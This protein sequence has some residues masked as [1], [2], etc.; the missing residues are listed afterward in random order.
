MPAQPRRLSHSIAVHLAAI[1]GATV[2]LVVGIGFLAA[3]TELS[4]AVVSSGVVVVE[5]NVKKVQHPTGGVVKELLV[6]DGATVSAGDIL[7]RL[8]EAVAN[9]NL[10]AVSKTYAELQA[11][12][13]RLEAERDDA[14]DIQFPDELLQQDDRAI[15]SMIDGERRLLQ[16]RRNSA[17]NRKSQLQRRIAQLQDEIGGLTDQLAAKQKELELIQKELA[18]VES[19]WQQQLVAI[20]RFTAL[21]REAARLLGDSGRLKA[22][23]AQSR[24][25][26]AETE[27]QILQVD[28]D[29]KRDVAKEIAEVRAKSEEIFEKRVAAQDVV[30]RIEIR[31]PQGGLVHELAVHTKGGVVAAGETLMMIVPGGDDLIVESHVQPQEIDQ[32]R[33]GSDAVLRFANL[34]Q[35]TTPEIVGR[36]V[37]IGADASRQ[38]KGSPA[39]FLVRV[40]I[41][42]ETVNALDGARLLPG[43]PAEVF[44]V[45]GER[46]VLSYLMRPVSEQMRRAFRER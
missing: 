3:S 29:A 41:P 19:L 6:K 27:L 46:T 32:V 43:M 44:I 31:A 21:Q 33:L 35:R 25:K 8:D 5:S 26:I 28:E 1:A 38:D 36:V 2:F 18:G 4:G 24:G 17:A 34:N 22:S 9:A 40:A 30:D 20:S 11:R 23:L 16:F 10:A 7:I 13:A 12:R 45:T 15:R 14:A 37:R 39:Y 42:K